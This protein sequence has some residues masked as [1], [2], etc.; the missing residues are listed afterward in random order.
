MTVQ[1]RFHIL[2]CGALLG[3]IALIAGWELLLRPPGSGYTLL[4]I[5]LLP[6]LLLVRSVFRASNYA[7][8]WSSLL[9]WLYFTEGVVRAYSDLLPWS[10]R[11]A[12]LEIILSLLYFAAVLG[13]LH[14]LKRA[15]KARKKELSDV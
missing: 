15:A 14:P 1:K 9:I 7:M 10:A 5:K 6:L 4:I 8:Q 2:A 12:V 11:C 13:Y 3:L